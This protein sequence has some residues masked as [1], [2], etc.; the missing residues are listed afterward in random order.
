M[1]PIGAAAPPAPPAA[2]VAPGTVS[3]TTAPPR[4]P[5]KGRIFL[6]LGLQ[7]GA[8]ETKLRAALADAAQGTEILAVEVRQT[9]SFVEVPPDAVDAVV[10]ALNA[11]DLEGKPFA[12]ERARRRR[13][14]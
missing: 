4:P 6:K 9:H 11:K 1:D 10:Q 8:D 5:A 2:D 7:E 3:E 12:A 14:S 13:R